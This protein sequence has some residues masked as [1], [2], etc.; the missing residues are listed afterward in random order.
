MRW[1]LL[2]G[3]EQGHA[4]ICQKEWEEDSREVE[5]PVR[6]LLHKQCLLYAK[7]AEL[8]PESRMC[9]I[10][11]GALGSNLPPFLPNQQRDA[12][13]GVH[14]SSNSDGSYW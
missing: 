3:L 14:P 2:E 9:S 13:E 1:K 10:P 5:T 4:M 11:P 6:W 12:T 7:P 8:G